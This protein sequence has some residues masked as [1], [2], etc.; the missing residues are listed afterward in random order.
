MVRCR[1]FPEMNKL[2]YKSVEL[3]KVIKNLLQAYVFVAVEI[4]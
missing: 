3:A 2:A 4:A 1:H